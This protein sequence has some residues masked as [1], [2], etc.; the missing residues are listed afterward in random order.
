MAGY[1]V[2]FRDG[3][4]EEAGGGLKLAGEVADGVAGDGLTGAANNEASSY[5]AIVW[6]AHG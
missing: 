4:T 3:D 5:S 2:D 1:I 6:V